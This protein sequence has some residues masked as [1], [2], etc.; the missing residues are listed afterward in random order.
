LRPG[1]THRNAVLAELPEEQKPIA[2]QILRGG[3]PAVRQAVEKQN[4]S[5]R[6]E[7]LPEVKAD[8]L[9]GLA[10][11]LLPRLRTAEWLD[12][13]EAAL[14]GIAELDLRDLRTVV[15]AADAAAR[16][17]ET[18]ALAQQL[19][20]ALTARVDGEHHAWLAELA[21]L[22]RDGRTVR[23]L[24]LSSHPPKAGAPLPADLAEQLARVASEGLTAEITQDR[25]ATLVDAVA[26]S[27]VRLNVTPVGVPAN[28]NDELKATIAKVGARVPQIAALLGVTPQAP[29]SRRPGGPVR[30]RRPAGGARPLPPKPALPAPAKPAAVAAEPTPAPAEPTEAPVATPADRA[31]EVA[32][33]PAS[34]D[35]DVA[36]APASGDGPQDSVLVEELGESVDQQ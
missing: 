5:A 23:A 34:G 20:D 9:L 1:R 35:E 19:R 27:P 13:A 6:A 28:P 2:E 4:E 21:E 22:V 25:W 7:G 11:Q 3:I 33:A 29:A 36:P 32:R 8:A 10:E 12:K 31:D 18:R 26:F 14:K 24:R 30:G 16:D 17:D 15:V